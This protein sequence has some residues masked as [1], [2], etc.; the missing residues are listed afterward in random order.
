MDPEYLAN[1]SILVIQVQHVHIYVHKAT[2]QCCM[3]IVI[4]QG[5]G[6][7]DIYMHHPTTLPRHGDMLY[8]AYQTSAKNTGDKR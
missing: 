5:K 3:T 2:E 7:R 8:V 4:T 1:H 6:R